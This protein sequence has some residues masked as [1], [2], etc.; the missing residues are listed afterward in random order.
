MA[1]GRA[2]VRARYVDP[3]AWRV[4]DDTASALA[5]LAAAGWQN[6]VLSDHVPELEALVRSLGLGG[7]VDRVI[8]SAGTAGEKPHREAFRTARRLCGDPSGSG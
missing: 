8:T 4:H 2:A 3:R 5:A 1:A 7:H 6:A